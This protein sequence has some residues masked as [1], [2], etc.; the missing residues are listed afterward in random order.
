MKLQNRVA[1]ITGG[2]TGIGSDAAITMA[3]EGAK[4]IVT[5]RRMEP[6]QETVQ[7]IKKNGGDAYAVPADV[8]VIEDIQ[9]LKETAME[10]YGRVDILVNNAGSSGI[11]PFLET[12]RDDFDRVIAID[13]RS[14]FEVTQAFAP[15]M[16]EQGRGSIINVSSI[17]G[18]FGTKGQATYCAAKGGLNNL[19]RALAAELGPAVRVNC[20]SPSH[21]ETPMMQGSLDYLRSTGK[22][23]KLEKMFPLKR[24]GYPQDTSGLI[25]FFASDDSSFITGQIM[26][27]DGGLSCYV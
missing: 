9:R 27:V 20:V 6:L 4:I 25:L 13:L 22:I 5:G 8:T 1:V 19:T 24:I 18:E 26:L 10:L 16:I 15:I 11:K 7:I 21:I 12:T 17:L 2:G 14:V 23:D 3:R